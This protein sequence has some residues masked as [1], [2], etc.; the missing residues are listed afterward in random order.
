VTLYAKLIQCRLHIDRIPQNDYVDDEPESTEL[1]LLTF[2]VALA[3]LTALAM[4]H[5]PR[6]GVATFTAI[7]LDQR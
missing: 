5:H 1:V 6:Q 2:A 3:Q 4:E 7:Q